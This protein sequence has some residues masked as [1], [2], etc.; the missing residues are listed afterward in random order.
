MMIPG[1]AECKLRIQGL[2]NQ[3]LLEF[4]H[5]HYCFLTLIDRNSEKCKL[6]KIYRQQKV[7][8]LLHLYIGW[9]FASHLK[10]YYIAL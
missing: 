7:N 2:K 10:M 4:D 9:G 5:V 1:R 8:V 6:V 3:C